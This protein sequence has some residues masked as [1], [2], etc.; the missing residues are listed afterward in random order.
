[1]WENLLM[2]IPKSKKSFMNEW[3]N[4]WMKEMN[5]W[6]NEWFFLSLKQNFYNEIQLNS[7][8]M[9]SILVFKKNVDIKKEY[10]SKMVNK[11][12]LATMGVPHLYINGLSNRNGKE[13]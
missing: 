7:T 6:M 3:M 9:C 13:R 1:M 12:W 5:E 4:E 8:L 2:K 11:K 10:R